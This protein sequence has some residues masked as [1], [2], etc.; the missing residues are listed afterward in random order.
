VHNDKI[1]AG[2][3][4]GVLAGLDPEQ[5]AAAEQP[6]PLLVVAG[7][8]T[9]K[10]RTLTHR[11]AHLVAERGVD[12]Q[13]CLAIT[14]TRR[15]AAEMAER[16]DA[17]G[18]RLVNVTTFHGLGLRI[19][20]ENA[21]RLG[22]TATVRVADEAER[23][24]L[25]REALGDDTAAPT[26]RLLE[27][28]SRLALDPAAVPEPELVGPLARYRAG[29]RARDL[30]DLDDLLALPV[31]LLREDP[32]LA[33]AYRERWTHVAVDEYQDVDAAQYALLRLLDPADLCAIG[34]PDQAIYSFRGA[35]VGFFLRFAEDFPGART[36]R[37]TRNYRSTAPVLAGALAAVAP[38]T[39]VPGR[40]LR[41]VAP[42][43]GPDRI[44]LHQAADEQAEAAF[45][46][47][48][49]E[50]LLGGSTFTALDRGI[51]DGWQDAV[52]SYADIAVLYRTDAQSRALVDALEAAGVPYQKRSHDRLGDRPGV[53]ELLTVLRSDLARAAGDPRP[54]LARVRAAAQ[55]AIDA[56]GGLPLAGPGGLPPATAPP[57]VGADGWSA[58]TPAGARAARAERDRATED[59]DPRLRVDRVRAALELLTPLAER[60]GADADRFLADIALGAEVDV[61]DPRADRVSLLT[62]HAV[63]GLEFPVVFL[64][65]CEDEL[66]PLRFGGRPADDAG[67]G[68]ERRLLFV[69]MTRAR[70]HLVL[71][72]A[73]RRTVRGEVRDTRPSRFLSDVP[74]V[75][76]ERTNRAAKR[77]TVQLRLL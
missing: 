40:D 44:A 75:L 59:A 56:A 53:R 20:R 24:V 31:A 4:G 65:G 36:V 74:D 58:L 1:G 35:D 6:G 67:I 68:E 18:A 22:L 14:F 66:L 2:L 19:V 69:G 28:V 48:T 49:V 37:L 64:T 17:L 70:T 12:T 77:R 8:G 45:V 51:A 16:L 72:W 34:D 55:A 50:R 41:A 10:T 7:P 27:L 73:A 54:V 32:A 5:R 47:G 57:A 42:G 30:V 76:L 21:H 3:G 46:L 61:W 52:H 43:R 25:A 71:S 62:L 9:G 23:L 15:A 33:A 29:K 60:A 11:L 39:L 26:R 13:R 38:G 63:K